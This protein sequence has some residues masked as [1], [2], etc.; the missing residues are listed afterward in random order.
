[1]VFD[2]GRVAGTRLVFGEYYLSRVRSKLIRDILRT[3]L[4][5]EERDL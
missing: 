5:R 4:E 2:S 3:S 1:M